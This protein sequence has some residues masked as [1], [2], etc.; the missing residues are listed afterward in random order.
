MTASSIHMTFK[1][2]KKLVYAV[3][4][5]L[6]F[7]TADDRQRLQ[8]SVEE[9]SQDYANSTIQGVSTNVFKTLMTN[10]SVAFRITKN[11]IKQS[12]FSHHRLL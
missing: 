9:F 8:A 11:I 12:A 6:G 10:S 7:T 3:G 2:V 4:L 5:W 1:A